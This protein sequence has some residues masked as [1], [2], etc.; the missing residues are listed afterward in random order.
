MADQ[1]ATQKTGKDYAAI[2]SFMDHHYRHFNARSVVRAA[3]GWNEQMDGGG[4]MF[5]TL[6]GAMST[7]E[8]G[9]SLAD[10]IRAGKVHGICCTGAGL[11]VVGFVAKAFRCKG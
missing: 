3:R 2:K 7:A 1:A 8:L 9:R 6:A 5:V 10:M 4:R 11:C